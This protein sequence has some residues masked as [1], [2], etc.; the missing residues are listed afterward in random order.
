M[1]IQKMH[2]MELKKVEEV[3]AL[4]FNATDFFDE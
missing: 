2:P 1:E 3:K 4:T